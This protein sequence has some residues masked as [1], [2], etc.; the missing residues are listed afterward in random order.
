VD[1][2]LARQHP[3]VLIQPQWQSCRLNM[4]HGEFSGAAPAV[5]VFA[6]RKGPCGGAALRRPADRPRVGMAWMLTHQQNEIHRE[7]TTVAQHYFPTLRQTSNLKYYVGQHI[8]KA[9][10]GIFLQ[11]E[12]LNQIRQSLPSLEINNVEYDETQNQLT[13][14]VKSMD[15]QTCRILSPAAPKPLNLRCSRFPARRLIPPLLP[16][17]INENANSPVKNRWQHYSPRERNLFKLCGGALCCAMVY[18]GAMMPL[19]TL[20]K[21]NEAVL[22]KQ[23]QTLNWM[24]QEIDK[25]HLQSRIVN[26]PN[27]RSVV[28]E[29]A[30]VVHVAL[31]NVRQEEQSLTFDVERVS[32]SALQNWLREMNVSS[33]IHLEK[34]A[35][36]PVDRQSDVK[37]HITLSWAKSA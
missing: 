15:K 8:S 5:R 31:T 6:T 4:L 16:G 7:M 28:E 26:T 2:L 30:K 25:N 35:L 20:I 37:A 11:L 18:Y 23:K 12:A 36:T 21:N 17:A 9:K 13:L 10:K 27:P 3:L 32:V 14:N 29:S 22:F 33:G 24:R 1:E 34:L 19:D